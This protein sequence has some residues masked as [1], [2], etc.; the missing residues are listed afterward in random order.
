MWNLLVISIPLLNTSSQ[1]IADV[2]VTS[3]TLDSQ[4]SSK[5]A[6]PWILGDIVPSK[7]RP[8]PVNSGILIQFP[9]N[10]LAEGEEHTVT[11]AGTYKADNEIR[12]FSFSATVVVPAPQ[13]PPFELLAAHVDTS[14]NYERGVW[15]YVVLNDE[16][17]QSLR[18]V[19]SF[20]IRTATPFLVVGTPPGWS[21]E[22]DSKTFVVWHVI[23]GFGRAIS[24]RT[25]LGG[26]A[27]Q[28]QSKASEGNSYSLTSRDT[29][30]NKTDLA[31]FGTV[32]TP[33]RRRLQ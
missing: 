21:V 26:F 30:L 17:S 5:L 10:G 15:D 33:A 3:T 13:S 23:S 24:A 20:Q 28:S 29:K 12:E 32:L 9:L 6:L 16:D 19:T 2:T 1:T 18:S 27:I 25:S 22:T 8:S 14:I 11:I 31:A 4:L 7:G